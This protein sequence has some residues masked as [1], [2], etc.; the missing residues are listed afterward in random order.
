MRA[1]LEALTA[2][3]AVAL[4]EAARR[5]FLWTAGLLVC[6]TLLFVGCAF[7]TFGAYRALADATGAIQACLAVGGFYL[8]LALVGLLIV[9]SRR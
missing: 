6:L 5:T 7:L 8:V 9:Q 1:L 2:T 4:A 3:G